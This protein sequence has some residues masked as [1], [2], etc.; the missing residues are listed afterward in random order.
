MHRSDLEISDYVYEAKY[1]YDFSSNL[2]ASDN[3]SC[4]V[5][6]SALSAGDQSE[7]VSV[8]ES[9]NGLEIW[10]FLHSVDFQRFKANFIV[11]LSVIIWSLKL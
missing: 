6:R 1:E 7:R 2:R 10:G 4:S 5:L 3:Q 11:E 9:G 8:R